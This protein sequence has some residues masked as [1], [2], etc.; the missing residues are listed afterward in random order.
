MRRIEIESEIPV[1]SSKKESCQT[2][3]PKTDALESFAPKRERFCILLES[4]GALERNQSIH[5]SALGEDP[6]D[7]IYPIQ[8]IVA[9]QEIFD[10]YSYTSL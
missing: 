9:G 7:E 10:T 5:P 3:R 6:N 4:K 8:G 2:W 1:A